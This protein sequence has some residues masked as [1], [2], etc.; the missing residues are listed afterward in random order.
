MGALDPRKLVGL[1]STIVLL[2]FLALTISVV[3]EYF[4]LEGHPEF[5][6]WNLNGLAWMVCAGLLLGRILARLALPQPRFRRALLMVAGFAPL[7]AV[8]FGIADIV[9]L[10]GAIMAWSLLGAEAFIYFSRGLRAHRPRATP[11]RAM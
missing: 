1:D 4:S 10:P 11:R 5:V 8:A 7:A 6:W 2:A 3:L 9:G